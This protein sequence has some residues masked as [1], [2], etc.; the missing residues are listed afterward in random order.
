MTELPMPGR[1]ELLDRPAVTP[2]AGII[3]NLA[4]P[5]NVDTICYLTFSL[6]VVFSSLAVIIRIYTK[7]VLL[8]SVKYDDC[9]YEQLI[10]TAPTLLT[11]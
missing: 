2:P 4:K 1:F 8:H 10:P 11:R 9:E 7:H 5:P 6:C 3:P